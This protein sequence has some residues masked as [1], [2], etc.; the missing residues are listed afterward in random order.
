MAK[1]TRGLSLISASGANE[2]RG[3]LSSGIQ[4]DALGRLDTVCL[5]R[6]G[7]RLAEV[8]GAEEAMRGR[9][10]AGFVSIVAAVSKVIPSENQ[11]AYRS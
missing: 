2:G 4:I 7:A 11:A 8:P 5:K 1:E 9:R 6:V 3:A 10:I